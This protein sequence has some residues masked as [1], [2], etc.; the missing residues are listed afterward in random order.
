MD[1]PRL[2][3]PLLNSRTAAAATSKLPA[4]LP[5]VIRVRVPL[6]AD[7]IP[8]LLNGML[9]IVAPAPGLLVNVPV[10][11][12]ALVP[13]KL[14]N[15]LLLLATKTLLLVNV[16]LA[17][18][19]RPPVQLV[20][21]LLVTNRNRLTSALIVS[22]PVAVIVVLPAPAI[23][24]PLQLHAPSTRT[25]LV[26]VS[27][28]LLSVS[29][30]PRLPTVPVKFAVP[31]LIVVAPSMSYGAARFT[32]PPL[33][34]T[35]PAPLTP[36]TVRLCVPP[37]K[38]NVAIAATAKLPVW[39]PLEIRYSVPLSTASVPLLVNGVLKPVMPVPPV[40][41]SV[42][43]L[44][45]ALAPPRFA[46]VSLPCAVNRLLLVNVPFVLSIR[47]P[48]Q[49]VVP[50][51]TRSRC[52]LTGALIVSVPALPTV[53][54]PV[55][56]CAPPL[57]LNVPLTPRPPTPVSVPPLMTKAPC[58]FTL[59]AAASVTVL[60]A[61]ENVCVPVVPPTD[62]LLTVALT[63]NVTVYVPSRV[64]IALSREPG[65]WAGLQLP[66]VPQFPPAAL[67]HEIS[68]AQA[69]RTTIRNEPATATNASN[70]RT[71]DL[72]EGMMVVFGQ[73][74]ARSIRRGLIVD[75]R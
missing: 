23:C 69:G 38:R 42:P 10:L 16:P 3:V 14:A 36:P 44:L 12:K 53:V 35:V 67:F 32:V 43:A 4:P 21:P 73:L 31:P 56:L 71:P 41:V 29:S 60:V 40:L 27:V 45:N 59:L 11:L 54:L 68:M 58:A 49:F 9:T 57:Q 6:C 22:V 47:P 8:V 33:N 37:A 34:C 26:P 66:G 15:E 48:V 63:S 65:T 24:P 20:V 19:I 52:R 70:P 5:P 75:I 51:L 64:M 55:P 28:P 39:L 17:K 25:L 74:S 1:A 2:K 72:L 30:A 7:T 50:L 62:R 46:N 13:E 18:P 61:I